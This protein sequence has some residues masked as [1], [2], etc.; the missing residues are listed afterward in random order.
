[1]KI[2]GCELFRWVLRVALAV[3]VFFALPNV[4]WL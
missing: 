2:S 1:V 3:V 4:P